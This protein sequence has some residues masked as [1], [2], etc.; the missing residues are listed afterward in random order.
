MTSLIVPGKN[1]SPE[2]TEQ[3]SAW[4][5]SVDPNIPLH[6]TRY[7]PRWKETVPATPIETL[8]NLQKIA[9]KHLHD[10]ILGNV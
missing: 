10:V 9:Q 2:E 6:L 7:F 4:L 1:D 5:A 3:L 8:E